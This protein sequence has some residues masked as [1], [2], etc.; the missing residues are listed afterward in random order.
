MGVNA[1]LFHAHT[2]LFL[3]FILSHCNLKLILL[4]SKSEDRFPVEA[5]LFTV[6]SRV[7]KRVVQDL[8]GYNKFWTATEIPILSF[9]IHQQFLVHFSKAISHFPHPVSPFYLF[10][11]VHFLPVSSRLVVALHI[12]VLTL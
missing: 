1:F 6:G 5:L 7:I 9:Q 2:L 11:S 8:K 10:E 12:S 4:K 3:F